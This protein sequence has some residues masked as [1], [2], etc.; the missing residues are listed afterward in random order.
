[1][2]LRTAR[3]HS[4]IGCSFMYVT[5]QRYLDIGSGVAGVMCR[6]RG[7]SFGKNEGQLASFGTDHDSEFPKSAQ[8]GFI[9]PP[10]PYLRASPYAL[11]S[12][13][14]QRKKPSSIPY[15]DNMGVDD[16]FVRTE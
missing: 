8:H 13:Q 9:Q 7:P 10:L 4:H 12:K 2:C 16:C 5:V 6:L 11:E 14:V 3:A 1:M 15:D